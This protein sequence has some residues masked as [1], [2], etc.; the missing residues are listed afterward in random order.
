[1]GRSRRVACGRLHSL[2]A[3]VDGALWAWGCGKNGQLGQGER[4]N[5]MTPLRVHT[6]GHN[7]EVVSCGA[8]HN[9]AVTLQGALLSWGC[10]KQGQLGH[11][12]LRDELLP[13]VIDYWS[14]RAPPKPRS[15]AEVPTAHACCP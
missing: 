4:Q 5:E 15:S 2:S 7:I 10:G 11:G 12:V 9:V 8:H 3:T 1:M 6:A 13:R 14:E